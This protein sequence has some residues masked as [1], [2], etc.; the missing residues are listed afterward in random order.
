MISVVKVILPFYGSILLKVGHIFSLSLLFSPPQHL[1][2][3]AGFALMKLLY[4]TKIRRI[5]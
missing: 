1:P 2:T 3:L 5:A 4:S